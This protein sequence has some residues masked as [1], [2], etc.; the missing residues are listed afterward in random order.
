[1]NS[2]IV[3]GA[4]EHNLKNI[5]VELPRN[6]LIVITGLSG[7]GKSSLAFDT[8]YAE[9]QRR[10][11][12]SLSSYARQFLGMMEKPDVDSIEGLSPAISIDQKASSKNP[13]STVGTITEIYDY[14]RVLFA[15]VGTPFCP[16]CGKEITAQTVDQ[17]VNEILLIE[18]DSKIQVTSPIVRNRKGEFSK[19]FEKLRKKGFVRVVVDGEIFHLEDDDIHL[20]KNFKHSID[21]VVDRLVMRQDIRSRLAEAVELA[22][23]ESEGL[24][25]VIA[26]DNET[27]YSTMYSCPDCG[28][29]LPEI[30]PR[31]FSF[32]SPQ[33]ACFTCHGLGETLKAAPELILD[34]EKSIDQGGINIIMDVESSKWY[35]ATLQA[36]AN[37]YHFKMSTPIKELSEEV[38]SVLLYGS[39]SEDIKIN[40]EGKSSTF[41]TKRPFEGLIP[42]IERRYQQTKSE[43]AQNYYQQFMVREKCTVCNGKRLKDE[44][45]SIK[46]D[47]LSI[48][49][50]TEKDIKSL[51]NFFEKLNLTEMKQKIADKLLTEIE[52]RLQFLVDVGVDY[53]N[54]SR[55]AETLSGGE[56]QR[57]RLATQIGTKLTGVLY[58]L[59]EPT[60]GLHQRDNDRLIKTLVNLRDLGNTLI[61]VE[62]DEQT[63]RTADHIVDMG[64][65]AGINGGSVVAQGTIAQ[66]LKE[67]ASLTSQYLRKEKV[68]P[69]P[70][71]RNSGNGN[72][73]VL[74]GAQTNNLKN[75]HVNFPLGS[76]I[77]IT[78]VSGSG[79]SS[80]VSETLLPAIKSKLSRRYRLPELTRFKDIE[81]VE[82]ID[83]II[84]IDQSPI[85]RTPRSNPATY[86]GL[87]TPIRDLFAQTPEAKTRGYKPGRFSFNVKGG[88]CEAC[89]GDGVIK[90]EMH[91]LPDVYVTCEACKGKRYNRETLE[92]LFKAR[93]IH[94]VLEMS[95]N[96][97]AQFFEN[98]PGIIKKLLTLQDVGLGYIKLGQKATT[99]SGGEAQRIKLSRELSKRGTG[100][101]LYLLD[102]PTTGLHFADVHKL[103]DVLNR[104]VS[105]GNTII[106]IE[107]NLDVIKSSDHIIDIGPEGG[108]G[109]G[110]IVVSGT[111]EE[112]V[113]E[114]K[115]YTGFYLK[116]ELV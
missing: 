94:D 15:R 71:G 114:K 8:I 97:A 76:F 95:V 44:V 100:K 48:V 3:R 88:R 31:I 35:R 23:E 66:I 19:L 32:N 37:H 96:E 51:F 115:S 101:T 24:V 5:T 12:E 72:A 102:E 47:N 63:I 107:H 106:V 29:S 84:D 75:I 62:H 56:M 85:G 61:V 99:L 80:L 42:M 50:L 93:N 108:D 77:V 13:R 82:H 91:F 111:P 30:H 113:K 69:V 58:V 79:K 11:V 26:N 39:G 41:T 83:K 109:G 22:I 90:I 20:K 10:Y 14:L 64:P 49:D 59:D 54:L 86:T 81:G 89:K 45:L 1:M 52:N 87:F 65:K 46:I 70:E 33:G 17:I 40:V 43:Y 7:S 104:L 18:D 25:K 78:G 16:K 9:G 116:E 34:D 57:I 53:L 98:Q 105:K 92:V 55:K 73:L 74:S 112:V 6:K 68:V 103:I 110:Y 27:L 28:F 38:V 67:T 4:R 2:I 36:L 60:I 21:V